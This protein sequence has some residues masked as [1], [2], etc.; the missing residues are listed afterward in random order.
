MRVVAGRIANRS[1]DRLGFPA[2]A[3]KTSIRL[4]RRAPHPSLSDAT[5]EM[6]LQ[7]EPCTQ[8]LDSGWQRENP[9]TR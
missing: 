6:I 7:N 1:E 5:Q 2:V 3:R 4:L 9:E 8:M